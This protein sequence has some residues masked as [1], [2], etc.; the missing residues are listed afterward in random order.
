VISFSRI[1]PEF[2]LIIVQLLDSGKLD[3][4]NVRFFV[5]DEAD[6]LVESSH[7]IIMKLY[8]LIPKTRELQVLMFSATLHSTSIKGNAELV[9]VVE[10][11]E[12]GNKICRFPT[13]V[14][15]KGKD[16]VPEVSK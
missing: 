8:N 14:D 2:S 13:W 5:L 10:I 15:L 1:F 6:A 3:V 7:P 11:V 12:L 16:A 4:S 9:V